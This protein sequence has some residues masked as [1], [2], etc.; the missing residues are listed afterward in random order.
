MLLEALLL[1]E[2]WHLEMK[3]LVAALS[4]KKLPE[5]VMLVAKPELRRV[6]KWLMWLLLL[7]RLQ[8]H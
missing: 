3:N 4:S 5:P 1:L 2:R 8:K 7:L 6:L